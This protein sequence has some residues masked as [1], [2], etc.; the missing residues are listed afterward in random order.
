[1]PRRNGTGPMGQGA[2]T[3][4]GLGCCE[5]SGQDT[6]VGRQGRRQGQGQGSGR[7]A[8]QGLG[9]S[10]RHGCNKPDTTTDN[11]NNNSSQ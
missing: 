8:C 11:N 6:T 2:R 3:G 5:A 10:F 4:R 1:M 9:K 7:G